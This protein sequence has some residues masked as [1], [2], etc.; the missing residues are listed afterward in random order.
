MTCCAPVEK[1]GP[2]TQPVRL[3]SNGHT[4]HLRPK[5]PAS[6]SA[7]GLLNNEDCSEGR[8]SRKTQGEIMNR[9]Q[10][11]Q[12]DQSKQQDDR[13]KSQNEKSPDT[14]RRSPQDDDRSGS[15]SDQSSTDR[16]K[17]QR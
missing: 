16:S 2:N 1:I 10:Q 5:D 12:R 7:S 17:H 3:C 9:D 6:D 8:C 13:S 4:H 15:K 11:K 14:M